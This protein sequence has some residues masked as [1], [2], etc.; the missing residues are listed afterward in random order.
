MTISNSVG[1]DNSK[2]LSQ[3]HLDLSCNSLLNVN[4]IYFCNGTVLPGTLD[5]YVTLNTEQTITAQKTF[6]VMPLN[7]STQ[8]PPTDDSTKM[9]STAWVQ[10]ALTNSLLDYVTLDTT[11]TISGEKTFSA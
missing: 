10:D 6:S 2:I 4:S 9:P 8:P 1:L 11:Q 7:T 5:N 3:S